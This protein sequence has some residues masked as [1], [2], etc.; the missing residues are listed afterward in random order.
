MFADS[1]L[2]AHLRSTVYSQKQHYVCKNERSDRRVVI[3][4]QRTKKYQPS[5]KMSRTDTNCSKYDKYDNEKQVKLAAIAKVSY[6]CK[7]CFW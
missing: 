1:S 4:P 7:D 2:T 6:Y 5:V 3:S